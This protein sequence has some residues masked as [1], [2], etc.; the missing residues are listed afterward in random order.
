[1]PTATGS[2]CELVAASTVALVVPFRV[3]EKIGG[4]GQWYASSTQCA[5]QYGGKYNNHQ[6]RQLFAFGFL[7]R[8]VVRVDVGGKKYLP[9]ILHCTC[10]SHWNPY[11]Y[12][13][14]FWVLFIF[15]QIPFLP[16]ISLC[17]RN[18]WTIPSHSLSTCIWLYSLT[19]HSIGLSIHIIYYC[20]ERIGG[21]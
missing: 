15:I 5:L 21:N 9:V 11:F 17:R 2:S 6:P 7:Q 3:G 8:V 1:M 18:V 12:V 19:H 20:V 13:L 16:L 14:C 4:G 10:M